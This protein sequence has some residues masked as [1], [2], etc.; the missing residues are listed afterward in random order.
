[1]GFRDILVEVDGER[2]TTA[3]WYPT[4]APSGRTTLGPFSMAATPDGPAGAG[5]Y[6]LVLISHGTEGGYIQR[7]EVVWLS[8]SMGASSGSS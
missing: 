6:G 4:E 8:S 5:P 2:L 7:N 1:M 3:L